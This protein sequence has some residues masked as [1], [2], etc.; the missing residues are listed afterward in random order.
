ML[1]Q[2][3]L[4]D[5]FLMFLRTKL[6]WSSLLDVWNRFLKDQLFNSKLSSFHQ[7]TGVL[8]RPS[9]GLLLWYLTGVLDIIEKIVFIVSIKLHF[10]IMLFFS[11]LKIHRCFIRAKNLNLC[12]FHL[13]MLFY[14]YHSFYVIFT[15]WLIWKFFFFGWTSFLLSYI[16]KQNDEK[17]R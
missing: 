9:I 6:V 15:F 7:L 17:Y 2:L 11:K 13:D 1:S 16:T 3:F 4:F 14:L 10:I 5:R 12:H 8:S